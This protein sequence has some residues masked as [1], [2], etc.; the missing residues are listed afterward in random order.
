MLC[1]RHLTRSGAIKARKDF[2]FIQLDQE[3]ENN[4]TASGI[5]LAKKT[6]DTI[7]PTGR[8]MSVGPEV[9]DLKENDHVVF[10]QY[11]S[12]DSDDADIRV[13]QEKHV[14]GILDD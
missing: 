1:Y 2:V 6:W 3:P 5:Y 10:M 9:K 11:A 8:V 7:P 13:V 12:V 14:L 4:K